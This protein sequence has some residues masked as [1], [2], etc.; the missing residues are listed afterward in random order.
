MKPTRNQIQEIIEYIIDLENKEKALEKSLEPFNSSYVILT[1]VDMSM[2][3]IRML[4][5]KELM[6]ELDYFLW[7]YGVVEVDWVQYDCSWRNIP[8]F[9]DYLEKFNY[10]EKNGYESKLNQEEAWAAS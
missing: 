6:Y 8:A 7:D 5:S 10:I 1:L 3:P 9:L 2:K 4:L